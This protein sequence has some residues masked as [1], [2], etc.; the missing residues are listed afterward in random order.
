[1]P[2]ISKVLEMFSY[3]NLM[4]F[5]RPIVHKAISF[6]MGEIIRDLDELESM[7]SPRVIKSHL[8]LY[9]LNPDLLN[10]SKVTLLQ[11]RFPRAR[12]K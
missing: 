2:L 5:M 11:S 9:L 8:P 12:D 4:D 1:M 6:T 10:T 7:T 3:W